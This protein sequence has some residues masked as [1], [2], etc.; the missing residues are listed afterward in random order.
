MKLVGLLAGVG[1][2]LVVASV[3]TG[4]ADPSPEPVLGLMSY[5]AVPSEAS[6]EVIEEYCAGCH[7]DR[8][9]SGNMS[10]DGF[11]AG[12][13][14]SQVEIAEQMIRKLRTGM[15][16]P[17]GSDRPEEAILQGVAAQLES[18]IDSAA[19]LAPN[20]GTRAFQR[21]NQAEYQSSIRDLLAL[22]ID[23]EGYLPPDT[24]SANFD[25]IADA[26]L[27]SPVLMDAYL[28]TAAEVARMAVG[29][30]QATAA[31]TTYKVPRLASQTEQVDG[32]PFGTRGGL[33]VVH[34]F[35]ADG[36]YRFRALMQPTPTGQLFGRTARDEMLE[37]SVDGE[38]VQLLE[39][40]R[41]MSQSDPDGTEI[42]SDPIA[43]RAGP[44]QIS[45][46]FI[47]TSEGPVVDIL[48][49]IGHSLADT[50]IGMGYGI[51]TLP[52]LRE[53]RIGGPFEVTGVSET[54]SRKE[55]FVC[56]PTSSS[57]EEPCAE[58]II[59]RLATKAYRRPITDKDRTDLMHFY[60]EG[61]SLDGFEGG[62]RTA[63][64][65][66]LASPHFIFRIEELGV[67]S[68]AEGVYALNDVDLASR[69]SFFLWGSP[70]DGELLAHARDGRLSDPDVYEAQIR[71]ML[72]DPAA[73]ALGHRFAAQW[74][75]LSDIE[76]VHPDAL[77]Y[78]DFDTQMADDMV[79][80]TT[81]FFNSLVQDDRSVLDLMTAD[82]TFVN[83]R[84][85]DHYGIPGIAGQDFVRV[86]YPSDDRR[87][88]LG[89]G[90]VLTLTSH[91][92]RTSPVLR[93]K[94]VMEVLLGS[95]PP[96]PP[97]D[98]PELDAA[99]ESADGRFLTVREQ[100]EMH[101]ANPSCNSCHS[102]IDPL[103]LALENFDV[104]GKWRI[105]DAGNPVDV[106]G[107]LYDG[108]PLTS[109][110]DLRQ[111]L[112]KR[113]EPFLR[114]FTE[115]LMAYAL[116]RRVESY[117]MPTVRAITRQAAAEDLRMSAFIMAVA[118]SAAFQSKTSPEAVTDAA[119]H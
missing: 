5:R 60:R 18:T 53:L 16:P 51:T 56:R 73:E 88:L 76:K 25:N 98:V 111:A 108:T 39:I 44:H 45:A 40:P 82:Y 47:V 33:S 87:G 24:K 42:Q 10:L 15:M 94:W 113:P 12:S 3:D 23:P 59:T 22:D 95:P 2:V 84:L 63:I 96:P 8:R 34:T 110:E 21:L 61:H 80:E 67:E 101:R 77:R 9:T 6:N 4:V 26:Q 106:Q 35:V 49:P 70:P 71:R 66:M 112:V 17:P 99:G 75:R 64:Q 46:A 69:L 68:D 100:M 105:K 11:D 93:G 97:P 81:R 38:R 115:N 102:V 28:N 58:R 41:W 79:E 54:P 91:A 31:E 72:A 103:G 55:I 20:P 83:Q 117:D 32:A 65:A 14:H 50:Q 109:V 43:V 104:T 78:P 13:A 37:I 116:G 52:H 19:A 118:Q 89:H 90:S 92:N 57:E 36:D 62:V 1:A 107:E 114:T 86:N 48:S 29:D 119:S 30:P 74:L 27:L 85:A 7:N